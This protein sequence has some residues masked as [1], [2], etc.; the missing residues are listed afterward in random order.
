MPGAAGKNFAKIHAF[1]GFRVIHDIG[2]GWEV[3]SL[4]KKKFPSH[5]IW[6]AKKWR[7]ACHAWCHGR[8]TWRHKILMSSFFIKIVQ[9]FF[10]KVA[11][12]W[13]WCKSDLQ[14]HFGIILIPL[15]CPAQPGKISRKFVRFAFLMS[16]W[17]HQARL[18]E[19][20]LNG[21]KKSCP[22]RNVLSL[23]GKINKSVS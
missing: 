8:H 12:W 6:R 20:F 4:S 9:I 3:G 10:K 23:T 11:N 15:P 2:P 16:P 18:G 5:D 17:R 14:D 7:H 21:E 13:K 19:T 1:R 22:L